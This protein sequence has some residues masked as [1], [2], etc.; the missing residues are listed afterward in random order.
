MAEIEL[1]VLSRQCIKRRI[2]DQD[3]LQ[4]EVQA[5]LK[6]RNAKFV[7]VDWRFS[8]ADARIKLKCLYPKIHD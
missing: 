6:D 1:S 4:K 5:W 7:K 3:N 2:P 8:A